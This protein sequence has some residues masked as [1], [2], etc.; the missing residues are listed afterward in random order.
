MATWLLAGGVS[1]CLVGVGLSVPAVRQWL[2]AGS[3]T[4]ITTAVV[5][6]GGCLIAVGL[7]TTTAG[8]SRWSTLA[9]PAGVRAAV[10][11]NMLFLA[12]FALE[13]SDGLVRSETRIHVLSTSLFVPTLL[14]LCGLVAGHRWA[15]WIARCL[16]GFGILWFLAFAAI[17]PFAELRTEGVPVPLWGRAWMIGVSF[18]LAGILAAAFHALGLAEAWEYFACE[19]GKGDEDENLVAKEV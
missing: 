8:L 14:L 1:A 2:E 5:S 19:S 18:A 9:M 12:F 16:A 7:A 10:A 13:I 11:A 15:W 6:L 4:G 3:L 17:V